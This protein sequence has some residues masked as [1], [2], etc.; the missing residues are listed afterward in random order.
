MNSSVNPIDN[1]NLGNEPEHIAQ[2]SAPTHPVD[3]TYIRQWLVLGPIFLEDLAEDLEKAKDFL[4]GVE[5]KANFHTQ[6]VDA[7]TAQTGK[8]LTWEQHQSKTNTIALREAV[9]YCDAFKDHNEIKKPVESIVYAF[10][11]LQSEIAGTA[12]IRIRNCGEVAVWINNEEKHR[13]TDYKG[14]FKVDVF[15]THLKVGDNKCRILIPQPIAGGAWEFELSALPPN[16][17]V[18]SGV[19]TDERGTPCPKANIRLEQNG[20]EIGRTRT[21]KDGKYGQGVYPVKG[22]YDLSVTGDPE[23]ETFKDEGDWRLGIRL[24]EGKCRTLNLRLKKAVR[25]S[26]TLRMLDNKTAHVS[27]PVQVVAGEEVVATTLS[28]AEGKYQFIN[29]KPGQ[30]QVR[31]QIPQG[32]IYYPSTNPRHGSSQQETS[33][34]RG[35]NWGHPFD[36]GHRPTLTRTGRF[37][38]SFRV[39]VYWLDCLIAGWHRFFGA[40]KRIRLNPAQNKPSSSKTSQMPGEILQVKRGKPLE[41]ID[42]CFARFKKGEWRNYKAL[43][44]LVDNRVPVIY[45]DRDGI[46]WVGTE[47]GLSQ[48]DGERFTNFTSPD[49]FISPFIFA[50]HQDLDG[51]L[52][53][54]TKEGGVIRYDGKHFTRL[55]RKDGLVND[56]VLAIYGSSDGTIWFGTWG[57]VS[58]YDG[59]PTFTNFTIKDGLAHNIVAA[60]YGSK[61]GAIW[62]GTWGGVS[63]YD[64]KTFTNFTI[65]D[66]LIDNRVWAIHQALDD[67]MWFGTLGGVSCYDGK[68]F[69][70]FTTQDGLVNPIVT[71]FFQEPD[72]GIWCGTRDG[73]VSR[74]DGETFVNFTVEDGLVHNKVG[75]ICGGPDGEVWFATHGGVSQY[76]NQAFINYTTVDGLTAHK[77][78]SIH[79]DSSGRMWFASEG[80]GV[81]HYDGKRFVQF[82]TREGL[83]NDKVW[84]IYQDTDGAIWFGTSDGVSRYDE[85]GF[86]NFMIDPQSAGKTVYAICQDTD[87]VMWFGTS[88]GIYRYDG[89]KFKGPIKFDPSNAQKV[90]SPNFVTALHPAPDGG[91]WVGTQGGLFR[92]DG[93]EHR[94]F[95]TQDGLAANQI[96]TIY[97]DKEGV[98][99]IGTYRGV[100]R[101]D[102]HKFVTHTTETELARDEIA[103]KEVRAI[104]QDSRG[105]LWFGRSGGF[106][107]VSGY[108]G[109]A[110]TTLDEQDGMISDTVN[111]IYQD[112]K[113]GLWFGTEGGVTRY[114]PSRVRP[115]VY[116][117]AVEADQTY[118]ELNTIPPITTQTRV[119]VKHHAIDFKTPPEKRQYLWRILRKNGEVETDWRVTQSNISNYTFRDADTYTFEVK[120]IDRDLNSSSPA[121]L[122]LDVVPMQEKVRE[123]ARSEMAARVIHDLNTPA[124]VAQ[125]FLDQ[126]I[127]ELQTASVMTPQ[128]SELADDLRGAIDRISKLAKRLKHWSRPLEYR[129]KFVN[130]NELVQKAIRQS[131]RSDDCQTEFHLCSSLPS[132]AVDAD[133]IDE[134]ITELATNAWE[135]MAY[136]GK[137]EIKTWVSSPAQNPHLSGNPNKRF[138]LILITDSGPGIQDSIRQ[139]IFTPGI[140][141]KEESSGLGLYFV[142][143]MIEEHGGAVWLDDSGPNGSTFII[144]LPFDVL[145]NL[146][147]WDSGINDTRQP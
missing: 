57:G 127:Q 100:S 44:R 11:I 86:T 82:T 130:I 2:G 56:A 116:I 58:R 101:F 36:S 123:E 32:S 77:I 73:G 93:N 20:L 19:I 147:N 67:V 60:I 17:A 1:F 6:V 27:V 133:D 80:G 119:S 39:V 23:H 139:R 118:T 14:L 138:I 120:A 103:S 18:I 90:S 48:F 72:G 55:T 40:L 29:L 13:S 38:Q 132:L 49:D 35:H 51:G 9:K 141:T 74:Y 12:E 124:S 144:A 94:R 28:D 135:A 143:M 70:D 65:K 113:G 46:M 122:T 53:F 88:D 25:I 146:K 30:Y 79:E 42:F 64:G 16:R 5:K 10:C 31:C 111:A 140:S 106:A 145:P 142:K 26:G 105:V 37:S 24:R 89:R 121:T 34:R 8:P 95:T 96:Y 115:K 62:F 78:W 84:T 85:E 7:I 43:D 98:M 112:S 15:E 22:R 83:A 114:K 104:C 131:R 128:I 71:S 59:G 63:R 99:W 134:S 76:N 54:G 47:D 33:K 129:K 50:I 102:G 108:D 3:G 69:T 137:L 87:D 81:F 61:D 45:R 117:E 136:K 107:G 126:L 52:W 66:G 4:A 21:D 109:T 68:G 91:M 125:I 110:W 97:R 41:A 75:S 92:Y